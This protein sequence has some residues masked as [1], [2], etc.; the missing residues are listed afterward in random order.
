MSPWRRLTLVPALR[1]LAAMVLPV[2]LGTTQAVAFGAQLAA[3]FRPFGGPPG[4]VP[5][6]WDMFAIRIE[7][8]DLRWD[9]PLPLGT[10]VARLHDMAP[11]L[12]W[13]PTYDRREEYR[14]IGQE[15]CFVA[16]VPT[17]ILLR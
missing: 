10:G 9:P 8:C 17:R 3:G 5:F 14:M 16:R 11:L 2:G 12:E 15:A 1:R 7:R 6:S 13:D 4:R